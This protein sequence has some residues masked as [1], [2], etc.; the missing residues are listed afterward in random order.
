MSAVHEAAVE[1]GGQHVWLGVWERNPRAIAF[2]SKMGFTQVGSHAFYVGPDCQ[3]DRVFVAPVH[4]QIAVPPN[5][6]FNRTRS[7]NRFC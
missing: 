3:T 5:P 6:A 4:A 2:Y 7:L 1:L